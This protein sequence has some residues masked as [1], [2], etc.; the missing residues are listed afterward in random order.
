MNDSGHRT[1]REP[2]LLMPHRPSTASRLP[3]KPGNAGATDHANH[4]TAPPDVCDPQALSPQG[5]V[6]ETGRTIDAV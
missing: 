4:D 1:M 6:F 3:R 5:G 2:G